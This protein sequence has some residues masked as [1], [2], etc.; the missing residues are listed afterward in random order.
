MVNKDKIRE[1]VKLILEGIGEDVTREGLLETP[2]RIAR[3]YEEI[4]SGMEEDVSV[5]LEKRFH[6]EDN[7][8]LWLRIFLFIPC[9]SIICFLF[10]GMYILL[11]FRMVKF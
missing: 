6:V 4:F 7:E 10:L 1:G 8:W 2:D 11:M 3:M 9:V 5:H